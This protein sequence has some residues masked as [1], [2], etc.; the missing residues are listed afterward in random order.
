MLDYKQTL[1]ELADAM[2][3]LNKPTI[4]KNLLEA[5]EYIEKLENILDQDRDTCKHER[6][7]NYDC[8]DCSHSKP[9]FWEP[10]E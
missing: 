1:R 10:K 6:F 5:A 2:E 3:R 4:Q 9:D 7:D 8:Y